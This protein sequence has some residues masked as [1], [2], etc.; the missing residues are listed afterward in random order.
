MSEQKTGFSIKID[1]TQLNEIDIYNA[2]VNV[3]VTL[4][5]GF[6]LLMAHLKIYNI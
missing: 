4:L 3:F 6:T 5:D 2:N 1:E